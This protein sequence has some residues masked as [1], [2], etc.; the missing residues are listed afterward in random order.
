MTLVRSLFALA[1]AGSVLG[2]TRTSSAPLEFEAASVKLASHSDRGNCRGGPGTASPGQFSCIGFPLRMLVSM[3]WG[4]EAYELSGPPSIDEARYI[5]VAKVPPDTTKQQFNVMLQTLLVREIG[6]VCHY[7]AREQTIYNMAIA[8]GGV[9]LREAEP[10]LQGGTVEAGSPVSA[11]RIVFD[12]NGNLPAGIPALVTGGKPGGLIEVRARSQEMNKIA[13]FV[14]RN[15]R[16]KVIDST[17]LAGSYDFV[18]TYEPDIPTATGSSATESFSG[19]S[20]ATALVQQLGLR[21]EA[22]SGMVDVLVV[23]KFNKKLADRL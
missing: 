8:K 16:R 7:E 17:G 12:K 2:Q 15:V 18:L 3:A 10:K 9:K 22:K 19:P 4:L 5:I 6:L 20:F 1:C 13:R 14:E 21:L 23:D 11:P